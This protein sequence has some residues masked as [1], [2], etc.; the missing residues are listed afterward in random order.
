MDLREN[1]N[2]KVQ[3]AYDIVYDLTGRHGDE[4]LN[5]LHD[6][7]EKAGIEKLHMKFLEQRPLSTI[8]SRKLIDVYSQIPAEFRTI[9]L[10][11][12]KETMNLSEN[13][14]RLFKGR[15]SSNDK[16]IMSEA[17]MTDWDLMDQRRKWFKGDNRLAEEWLELFSDM[18]DSMPDEKFVQTAN[19]WLTSNGLRWQVTGKL[20][21]NQEGEITWEIEG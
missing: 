8:E 18:P 7:L 9:G 20:D 5:V 14:K 3:T 2:A 19:E 1:R 11:E 17:T 12:K 15:I 10:D 21:Q 4:P 13:Y 6:F 16:K